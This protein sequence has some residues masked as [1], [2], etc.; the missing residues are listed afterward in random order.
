MKTL[1]YLLFLTLVACGGGGEGGGSGNTGGNLT[2]PGGDYGKGSGY[3]TLEKFKNS[4]RR[5]EWGQDPSFKQYNTYKF[6]YVNPKA[7]Q[8]CSGN[9]FKICL[10]FNL[11]PPSIVHTTSEIKG[12]VSN[13]LISL[14]KIR[15]VV[16]SITTESLS[17]GKAYY[18]NGYWYI[19]SG[20][21]YFVFFPGYPL[22]GNPI[23]YKN[24]SGKEY[25]LA[26]FEYSNSN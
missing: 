26:Y 1:L 10:N 24:S 19:Q 6:K 4:V 11:K 23:F 9:I 25:S 22:G 8:N 14:N 12:S 3:E 2:T 18:M 16:E 17:T 15:Q 21:E 7:S 5:N 13:P 20:N